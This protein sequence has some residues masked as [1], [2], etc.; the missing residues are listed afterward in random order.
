MSTDIGMVHDWTSPD[1]TIQ[2]WVGGNGVCLFSSEQKIWLDQEGA[3]K[4]IELL[5]EGLAHLT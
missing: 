1:D 4:L 3:T 2:V 5:E